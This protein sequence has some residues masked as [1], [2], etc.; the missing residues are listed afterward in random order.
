MP[1]S[2]ISLH[3]SVHYQLAGHRL[4]DKGTGSV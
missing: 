1:D 4:T 2:P 3:N